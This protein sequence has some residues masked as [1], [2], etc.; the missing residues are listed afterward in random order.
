MFNLRYDVSPSFFMIISLAVS[1]AP[2]SLYIAPM[3]FNIW[4]HD[5]SR[6][7][8]ILWMGSGILSFRS[9]SGV[10]LFPFLE[11]ESGK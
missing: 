1:F 4:L 7:I 8:A 10:F 6:V 11:A 3:D 5:V 2:E 9:H